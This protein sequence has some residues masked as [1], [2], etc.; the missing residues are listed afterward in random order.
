MRI[1]EDGFCVV[2]ELLT[3]K[4]RL[5]G[6]RGEWKTSLWGD[7]LEGFISGATP[8]RGKSDYYKGHIPWVSS[9][10]LNRCVI[11]GT[12][13]HITE[14]AMRETH[15]T[16]HPIGTFLMAITGLEAEGTRGNCGILGMEATTNQSCMAIYGTDKMIAKYLYYYY[17]FFAN[18]L[19]FRY[20][21]GTKQQSYTASIV[22]VLPIFHPVDVKEQ[23]AIVSVLSDLDDTISALQMKLEKYRRIKQGMMAELLSGR[24][25]LN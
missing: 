10:E 11:T 7:V 1:S 25:R 9:G 3:G 21:Q 17:C 24:I 2:K 23:I 20:C 15:L 13:E 19:A 22:K 14:K 12:N 18:E 5:K 8:Y 16:L 6:F 4:R